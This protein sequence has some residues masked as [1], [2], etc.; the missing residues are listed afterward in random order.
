MF[1]RQLLPYFLILIAGLIWGATFSLIL[2]AA[3]GGVHPL[4]LTAWQ[5]VLT[6]LLY[7]LLCLVCRIPFFQIRNLRHYLVLTVVGITVPTGLYYYA[8]PNL[9]AGILSITVSTV[10]LLTYGLM[11]VMRLESLIFKRVLGIVLGMVAILL[12]VLPEQSV[13]GAGATFW[14]LVVLISAFLYTIEN[15]Y[16]G[17]AVKPDVDIRE[18]LC[19]ANLLS[20]FILMGFVTVAGID[21]PI[22]WLFTIEGLALAGTALGSGIAYALFFYTIKLSGP[23]FASQ[24]AYIVTISG[25]LWGIV[26]FAEQHSLWVW[27]SVVVMISGLVLVTPKEK[28]EHFE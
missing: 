8:A 15:V 12:L 6:A 25:V 13:D 16:I 20:A 21:V 24:C 10:P 1:P 3:R 27:S 18:L 7:L 17:E 19:G 28:V 22:D 4:T 14:I 11:L 2:I 26:I 23:V 5:V 9:S